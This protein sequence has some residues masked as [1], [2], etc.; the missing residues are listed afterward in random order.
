M[1]A[2]KKVTYLMFGKVISNITLIGTRALE[3]CKPEFKSRFH[4]FQSITLANLFNLSK[5]QFH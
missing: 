2:H 5:P 3:S 1:G 4:W